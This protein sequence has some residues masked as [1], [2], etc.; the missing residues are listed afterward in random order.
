MSKIFKTLA[1]LCALAAITTVSAD[2]VEDEGV[3]VLGDSDLAQAIKEFEYILVEFYAPWCGHCKRLAPEYVKAA[4][5]LKEEGSTVKLAKVD[6]TENPKVG[7]QYNIQGYPTLKFFIKGEEMEYEGGRTDKEI[8]NWIRRKT[9]PSTT[10]LGSPKHLTDLQGSNDVVV[11]FFGG[12]D[13]ES[14][15]H[16]ESVSKKFDDAVFVYTSN[17]DIRSEHKVPEG[18]HVVLF[19]KFDEGRNELAGSF[20]V[21]TL[22]KFIEESSSPLVLPFDQKAAQKIFG[23]T[24]PTVFLI[25]KKDEAGQKAEA[26]FKEAAQK[27]KGQMQFSISDIN[28]GALG[29]RLAEFVGVQ[30]SDSPAIRIVEPLRSAAPKK[31]VFDKEFTA[32][33][34]VNFYQDYKAGK[35]STFLKSEAIPETNDEPVKVVVGK[36]FNDIVLDPTKDVF[37]EFYAPWC[38]HCKKLAPIWDELATE[39]KSISN[40]VIAKMDATAN[41]VES[42]DVSGFP[43]L[44]FY[45]S[46][47]KNSPID[48]DGDRTKEALLTWLKEKLTVEHSASAFTQSG[49]L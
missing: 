14:Y 26:A 2:Y 43:T 21:A 6:A 1:L 25:Y 48:Y 34:I 39:L 22:T 27:L 36:N 29:P 40:L 32:E 20:D 17:A 47:S 4:A 13:H 35:I 23:E 5:L 42:V 8:V 46:N 9:Q 37:I 18:T 28:D 7:E 12:K 31:Y 38:G 11:V 16:F 3:L 49:E 33:N 19:K 45:P 41:E 44:K 15:S 24:I 10:E 30:E